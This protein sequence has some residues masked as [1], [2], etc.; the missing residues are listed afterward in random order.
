M[1]VTCVDILAPGVDL[2]LPQNQ[3]NYKTGMGLGF[4]TGTSFASPMVA[5]AAAVIMSNQD[6][7]GYAVLTHLKELA[8]PTLAELPY[9]TPDAVLH[10][11]TTKKEISNLD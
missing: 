7:E 9:L 5:G 11:H 3:K 10:L 8:L 2:L 1:S 6:I 4:F